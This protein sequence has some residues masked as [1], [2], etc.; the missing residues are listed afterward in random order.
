[1]KSSGAN[2]TGVAGISGIGAGRAPMTMD[3]VLG[4][5]WAK[6]VTEAEEAQRVLISALN[7]LAALMLIDG[8]KLG[9][10][11]ARQPAKALHVVGFLPMPVH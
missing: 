5:L 7:G 10:V 2:S 8:D 6:A 4:V 3:E 9:A 1:M 11:R